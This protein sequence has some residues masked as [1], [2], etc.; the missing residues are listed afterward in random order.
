MI[1]SREMIKYEHTPCLRIMNPNKYDDSSYIKH[2]K[3]NISGSNFVPLEEKM[4]A[5]NL[6]IKWHC[7]KATSEQNKTDPKGNIITF[8]GI[9]E[10]RVRTPIG[11]LFPQQYPLK[12][13]VGNNK[14]IEP[15]QLLN[16]DYE[17]SLYFQNPPNVQMSQVEVW[18]FK[19]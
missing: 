6:M 12:I 1:P 3:L 7:I 5:D 4:I 19:G 2:P 9:C 18:E 8:K 10:L 16:V 15:L 14:F 11:E 13:A 17:Y